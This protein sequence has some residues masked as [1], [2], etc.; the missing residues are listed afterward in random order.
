MFNI[1]AW[2]LSLDEEG[3]VNGVLVRDNKGKSFKISAKAVILACG[4]FEGN[5]EMLTR[6]IGKEAINLKNG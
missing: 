4:G 6:Y 3:N 1:T 2:K 5:Y